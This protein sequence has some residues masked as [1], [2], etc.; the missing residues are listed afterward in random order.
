MERRLRAHYVRE[1]NFGLRFEVKALAWAL[2][3]DTNRGRFCVL[4]TFH[5]ICLGLLAFAVALYADRGEI[6]HGSGS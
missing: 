3:S 4:D 1:N 6:I 5:S 2:L